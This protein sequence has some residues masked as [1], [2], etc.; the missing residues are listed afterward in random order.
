[1]FDLTQSEKTTPIIKV[2]RES[3]NSERTFSIE[4]IE[5]G[6]LY[7]FIN[8]GSY[9]LRALQALHEETIQFIRRNINQPPNGA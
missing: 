5:K 9:L 4:E 1:M 2:R 6:E 8:N 3:D 7:S